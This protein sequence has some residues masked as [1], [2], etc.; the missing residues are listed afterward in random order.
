M[1]SGWKADVSLVRWVMTTTTNGALIY[2]AHRLRFILTALLL[3]PMTVGIGALVYDGVLLGDPEVRGAWLLLALG[4]IYLWLDYV[5]VAKLIS[6]PEFEV[7]PAGIRWQNPAMLQW[8]REYNWN[9]IDGPE[10]ISGKN[11]VPLLQ[12]VVKA[13]GR[14]L[15]LPPSHFG[16]TYDEMAAVMSAARAGTFNSP[17]RWRAEHPQH[18]LKHWVLEW[19]LP[20]AGGIVLALVL[21]R[22]KH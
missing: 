1:E 15:K 19:G 18:P 20:L 11:G 12:V 10:A 7:S 8:S 4:P 22:S 5:T 16:A 14:K 13:S 3:L 9:D 21:H 6:P 2:R 17:Q